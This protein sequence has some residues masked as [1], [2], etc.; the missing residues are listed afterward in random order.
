M[1]IHYTVANKVKFAPY[2][3]GLKMQREKYQK[4]KHLKEVAWKK[5]KEL[6]QIRETINPETKNLIQLD[7]RVNEEYK[8][9]LFHYRKCEQ[10]HPTTVKKN[11]NSD[12]NKLSPRTK[13]KIKDS[14]FK[15]YWLNQHCVGSLKWMTFTA[16]P[17]QYSTRY[18][19]QTDDVR[20]Q[21][22]FKKF[23]DNMKKR[24]GLLY[25]VYVAERQDGKRRKK[26]H[27]GATNALHYHA[28]FQFEKEAPHILEMNLY[29][30]WCLENE[31]F[32]S[33]SYVGQDKI[34]KV[35][36][37]G[38]TSPYEQNG[39]L[40]L[41]KVLE[42]G[43]F[44]RFKTKKEDRKGQ[45]WNPFNVV[46]NPLDSEEI[47]NV[48]KLR[49]YLTKYVSKNTLPIYVR[50]WGASKNLREVVNKV[51]ISRKEH[52]ELMENARV[53]KRLKSVKEFGTAKITFR[54]DI[55]DGV[56]YLNFIQEL[57]NRVRL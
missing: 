4:E 37:I 3:H 43:I 57:E 38:G 12:G 45:I 53:V 48:D 50:I 47:K 30:C 8:K 25:Y 14:V 13:E 54:T 44:G 34:E 5:F 24:H 19:P 18:H 46:F 40:T 20:V 15:I 42:N 39:V 2:I 27:V 22:A 6:K 41:K 23:L 56:N 9:F 52:A 1:N 36:K 55:L 26:N 7:K 16:T 29:W 31:G 32:R 35:K 33:I 11:K 51:S 28:I 17:N 21:K 49:T 10:L